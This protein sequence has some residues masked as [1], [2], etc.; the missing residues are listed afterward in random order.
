MKLTSKLPNLG[1]TIFSEMTGLAKGTRE[2][3]EEVI[4]AIRILDRQSRLAL[5]LGGLALVAG[6]AA[7][8]LV[9]W[10][11]VAG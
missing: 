6:C 5:W 9:I 4:Q 2:L 3:S 1:L 7:L 11:A 8:G 10:L